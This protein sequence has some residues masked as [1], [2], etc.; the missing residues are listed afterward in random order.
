MCE[1]D[2]PGFSGSREL[3][4]KV[5][6]VG[7]RMQ[8]LQVQVWGLLCLGMPYLCIQLWYLAAGVQECLAVRVRVQEL[9][10]SGHAAC[11]DFGEVL[12]VKAAM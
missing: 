10:Y 5:Q 9:R 1:S 7:N 6:G 8:G 4:T 3:W 11:G 12:S 2:F